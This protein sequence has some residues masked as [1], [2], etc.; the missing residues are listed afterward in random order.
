MLSSES[1][2][3]LSVLACALIHTLITY[4]V[5]LLC[6]LFEFSTLLAKRILALIPR[7]LQQGPVTYG[8]FFH[9]STHNQPSSSYFLSLSVIQ[10]K[11]RR[12]AE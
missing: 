1:D 4:G 7:A 3:E 8:S 9:F 10:T 6:S 12:V 5:G 2:A 11:R